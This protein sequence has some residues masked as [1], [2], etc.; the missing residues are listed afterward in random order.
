MLDALKDPPLPLDLPRNEVRSAKHLKIP[1]LQVIS[2]HKSPGFYQRQ[3][4]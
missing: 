3:Q 4:Y 2:R 1:G